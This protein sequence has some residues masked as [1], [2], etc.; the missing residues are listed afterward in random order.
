[1]NVAQPENIVKSGEASGNIERSVTGIKGGGSYTW[2]DSQTGIK[3][4]DK[5]MTSKTRIPPG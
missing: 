5:E 4:F 3:Y 1:M 2:S